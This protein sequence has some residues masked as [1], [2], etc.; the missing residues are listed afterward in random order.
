MY[1]D[2]WTNSK[3]CRIWQLFFLLVL[4]FLGH[5]LSTPPSVLSYHSI[6]MTVKLRFG[7]IWSWD[8]VFS[9]KRNQ[10]I[11]ARRALYLLLSFFYLLWNQNME[12]KFD[13]LV[14]RNVTLS[15]VK[16][17]VRSYEKMLAV[18]ILYN[19]ISYYTHPFSKISKCRTATLFMSR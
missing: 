19:I 13:F 6:I 10:Y 12:I 11:Y 1:S 17:Y 7:K 18:K 2:L 4:K 9:P 15:Y 3:F 8:W 16:S 5:P 14:L